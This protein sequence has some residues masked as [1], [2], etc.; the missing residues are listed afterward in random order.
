LVPE[1]LRLGEAGMN[2]IVTKLDKDYV[3]IRVD[4]STYLFHQSQY[5]E[6]AT[7]F[8]LDNSHKLHSRHYILDS[9]VYAIL[10]AGFNGFKEV[11]GG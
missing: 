6:L 10:G 9:F 7:H 1:S 5:L 2:A 8:H 11:G 3:E 4:N